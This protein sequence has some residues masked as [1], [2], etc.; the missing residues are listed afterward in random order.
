MK[1]IVQE[2]EAPAERVRSTGRLV[3]VIDEGTLEMAIWLLPDTE[4]FEAW[5]TSTDFVSV[6]LK[7]HETTSIISKGS[8]KRSGAKQRQLPSGYPNI[9]AIE[10]HTYLLTIPSVAS[11]LSCKRSSIDTRI[12]RF[13]SSKDYT[14]QT[15]RNP[16]RIQVWESQI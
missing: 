13:F 5:C 11:S 3:E 2:I 16:N 1:D 12:L 7:V 15:E 4:E 10:D 14:A 8:K 9:L 6:V